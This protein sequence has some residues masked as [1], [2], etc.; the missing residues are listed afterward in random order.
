MMLSAVPAKR[1]FMGDVHHRKRMSSPFGSGIVHTERIEYQPSSIS[2]M[3]CLLKTSKNI[4]SA[5]KRFIFSV[6]EDKWGHAIATYTLM[7]C[8]RIHMYAYFAW[9]VYSSIVCIPGSHFPM[10]ST[11][12]FVESRWAHVECCGFGGLGSWTYSKWIGGWSPQMVVKSKGGAGTFRNRIRFR[13]C[14]K[15]CPRYMRLFLQKVHERNFSFP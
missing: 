8:Q 6:A 5:F 12:I 2:M 1:L 11:R 3:R 10:K 7:N 15:I 14:R 9:F 4:Q 13:N